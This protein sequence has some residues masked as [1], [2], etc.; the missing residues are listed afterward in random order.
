MGH[1]NEMQKE[2]IGFKWAGR[3]GFSLIEL[4]IVC[5]IIGVLLMI[6]IPLFSRVR[7][8][9]QN[10]RFANDIRVIS[11][12]FDQFAADRGDYPPESGPSVIPS[13]MGDYLRRAGWTRSTA[14]GGLWDWDRGVL[15]ITAGVSVVAFTVPIEQMRE[16]DKMIDDGDA[17][18]GIFRQG[19]GRYT[20]VVQQ[21]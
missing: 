19:G 14:V 11:G 1:T 13:G 5:L 21:R 15:G 6:A 16:L 7:S 2:F 8:R 3:R 17:S 18:H 4:M 10:A 20:Y 9:S 12:A